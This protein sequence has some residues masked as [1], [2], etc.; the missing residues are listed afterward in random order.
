MRERNQLTAYIALLTAMVLWG[1][2]FIALK[3]A[4]RTYDPLFV[5]FSRMILGLL[6]L[7]PVLIR[8]LKQ[9]RR[10]DIPL[11]LFM[12]FC[13]PCLYFLFEA[14]ALTLTSASQAG[15]ITSL[16][17]LLVGLPA[18]YYLREKLTLRTMAGYLLAIAGVVWL[19]ITG[20]ESAD[21][22]APGMGNLLELI[23]MVCAAGYTLTMK[24]LTSRYSALF[25]TGLQTLIGTL[26]FLPLCLFPASR[27]PAGWD[28]VAGP[29]V[30][31]LGICVTLGGY[32]MFNFGTSRLPASRSSAFVNLIPVVTLILSIIILREQMT[33]PQ[34]T[35]S[36][37][38]LGGVIV[39]QTGGT[40]EEEDVPESHRQTLPGEF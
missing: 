34:L 27:F 17:P 15:M 36:V 13:E 6:V 16:L 1:S 2:S 25:L 38:I 10:E 11:I 14:K 21:A 24:K 3:L 9:I 5:I 26:F 39:S 35:A 12:A 31:Y 4:F 20:Q 29:A 7:S 30:I 40:A 23:A 18:M 19:S 33:L 8:S 37:L 32:G 22:P 28:P